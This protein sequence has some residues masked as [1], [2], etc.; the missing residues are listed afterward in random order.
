MDLSPIL[1]SVPFRSA[2]AAIAALSSLVVPPRRLPVSDWLDE[3]RVISKDYPS[4][5]P[6]PWRTSRTPYLREPMNAFNDPA[7][8]VIVLKFSS[9]VGKTEAQLGMLMYA[10]GVDP[11]PSMLVLPILDLA[12]DFS[13]DRLTP[14]LRSCPELKVGAYKSRETDNA[15]RHKKIN[16]LPLTQRGVRIRGRLPPSRPSSADLARSAV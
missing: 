15:T 16:G 11:A 4:P 7:V 13:R 6:G 8:E 1:Q 12:D 5:F 3:N 10:Y 2:R 14:A 9:Q